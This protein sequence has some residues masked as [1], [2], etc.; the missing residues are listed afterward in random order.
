VEIQKKAIAIC[1]DAEDLPDLKKV[2]AL[3][4]KGAQQSVSAT[5]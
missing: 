4:E 5:K 1:Q 3:Y 2:L